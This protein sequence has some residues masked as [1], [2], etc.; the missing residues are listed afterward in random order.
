MTNSLP[1][2]NLLHGLLQAGSQQTESI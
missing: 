1:H 2:S